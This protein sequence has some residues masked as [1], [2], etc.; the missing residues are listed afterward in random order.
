GGTVRR[1]NLRQVEQKRLALRSECRQRR[2][3][4]ATV[5]RRIKL[6]HDDGGER[7]RVP[8]IGQRVERGGAH[9]VVRIIEPGDD[10]GGPVRCLD[11]AEG[12]QREGAPP[13]AAA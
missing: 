13:P 10:R 4:P 5:Q 12:T 7:C 6:P 3:A 8:Q 2:G 9:F 11:E 1:I